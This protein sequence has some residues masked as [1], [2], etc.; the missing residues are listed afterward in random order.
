VPG[1]PQRA[2]YR[3]P[4]SLPF[5]LPNTAAKRLC[6]AAGRA[7]AAAAVVLLTVLLAPP[8]AAAEAAAGGSAG[9][10][11]GDLDGAGFDFV[12]DHG[13]SGDYHLPEI[14][15]GGGAM[16][17]VDGDGD[18]DLFLVQ[19]APLGVAAAADGE[20]PKPPASDR[21][22]R[23]DLSRGPDGAPR[24]AFTD[25]TAAS[26]VTDSAYGCGVAAGDYD[27]DGDVDL[28]VANFG[29]NR[30]LRNR[31]DGSFEDA[32]AAAGAGDDRWSASALWTDYDG[33][34][35]L[36]LFVVNYVAFD[37]AEQKACRT[38][39]GAPDYC[40]PAAYDGVGNRLL[41]NRG[42][43]SFE[44][45]TAAAGMGRARGKSL[46]AVAAD[47]DGDGRVDLY[48][49]NDGEAN[50]LW[51]Q[52]QPGRFT[53]SALYAGCAVNGRGQPEASMGVAAEDD[54]GDGD[55]DLLLTHLTGE[56]HTLY[57]NDG[58]GGFRDAT[59]AAGLAAP[60]LAAT[61]WG[62]AWSD[63][64]LDGRLDLAIADG[65]VRTLPELAAAGDPFPFHQRD[66]LF[67]QQGEPGRYVEVTADA[68]GAPFARSQVSRGLAVGDLDN[69]GDADLLV[70]NIGGPAR[71]LINRVGQ[72]R[73][74][75]GLRLVGPGGGDRLGAVVELLAGGKGGESGDG[76]ERVVAVRRAASDGSF[77][78]ARDPRV[79]FALGDAAGGGHQVRVRWPDGRREL[80][81]DLEADRY[82][83]L[84]QGGGKEFQ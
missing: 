2:C 17:D 8:S 25:V 21:L 34:G 64:D 24:L 73:H 60:T 81:S 66:Q 13:W 30:L 11:F 23:N 28:Y 57:R 80:F 16:A 68:G 58:V 55:F 29:A 47:L 70:V 6:S 10:W 51:L 77:A 20:T 33:D 22:F 45:A 59:V 74:W 50:E 54:D 52:K 39:A 65:A 3:A 53:E 9:A 79:V 15:C 26:G 5:V 82:T 27:G 43:G 67:R 4:V 83:T 62:V 1:S 7:F 42:D 46:G 61:G 44:D 69:D 76:G 72:D 41:R 31:G 38:A 14:S 56:T 63:F 36:D 48:V 75:L 84:H 71:V 37:P 19:G 35:H 49:T 40:N 18:L 12:Y 32:T 78:S